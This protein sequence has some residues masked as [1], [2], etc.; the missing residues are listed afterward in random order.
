MVRIEMKRTYSDGTH[1]IELSALGLAEKLAAIVPPPRANTVI[2]SGVLAANAALRPDVIPKAPTST[3][4]E[5]A[6][7]EARKLK[8]RDGPQPSLRAQQALSWADLLPRVPRGW[9]GMSPVQ[10]ANVAAD[11]GDRG[12]GVHAHP[13]RPPERGG[14]TGGGQRGV[15]RRA[16]Q[17]VHRGER[18]QT[19]RTGGH[20][21]ESAGKTARIEPEHNARR[22]CGRERGGVRWG[23]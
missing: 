5:Q 18:R 19:R 10:E 9:L 11:R 13:P 21:V 12:P 15:D 2:Y 7:R 17:R 22:A 8:R 6:A 14:S 23:G 4:A 1:A 20:A 16:Q 3:D